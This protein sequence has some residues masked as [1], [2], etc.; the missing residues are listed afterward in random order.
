MTLD[1]AG[2][3]YFAGN[4]YDSNFPLT[5]G[6]LDTA[7]P[8]YP[9]LSLVVLKVDTTGK[10]VYST[11]IPT[12]APANPLNSQTNVLESTALAVD[13]NGQVTVAGTAGPGLPTTA[14]ALQPV[15]PNQT[16]GVAGFLLQLN[17]TA[18]ALNYATYL[19]G[20][21][22]AAGLAVAGD[23]S[24]YVA[25][26]TQELN[27][28]VSANAYDKALVQGPDCICGG[29]YILKLDSL[30]KTV[31]AATYLDGTSTAQNE[32]A[33]LLGI[34]LDSHSNVVVGGLTST[35]AF[36]LKNPFVSQSEISSSDVDLVVAELSS[37]LSALL[38]S[39][40]LNATTGFPYA[41]SLFTALA[42]DPT[43]H[44]ILAG[45]TYVNS[46][47]TTPGSFEPQ[48]PAQ[49]G[50]STTSHAFLASLNLAT[51]APSVCLNS[52]YVNFGLVP[53]QT[54]G[55]QS[56][57]LFNC[58]NAALHLTS[59][60]S[61]FSPVAAT[62]TCSDVAAGATCTIQLSFTPVNSA[63]ISGQMTLTDDAAIPTQIITFE[64]QGLAS[65]LV[66]NPTSINFGHLLVGTQGAAVPV[67]LANAGTGPLVI[68]AIST[69]GDFSIASNGCTAPVP[70]NQYCLISVVFTPTA[71]GARTGTVTIASND[72]VNPQ[73]SVRS[74]AWAM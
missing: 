26:F 28:P 31:I 2:N 47:P 9:N 59:Y 62:G 5:P 61:S 3:A 38:F 40:F 52:W 54:T 33:A 21:D 25:G 17:S 23:G 29:G 7:E 73:L 63:S 69:S 20:T 27:L 4:T 37:D 50:N 57:T 34:S 44:V 68:S 64:G 18:T 39:S 67:Y 60:L 49:P 24:L 1:S 70:S 8:A 72:P 66:P 51:P 43:D 16:S 55:S 32:G 53:M 10:L 14:G 12:N 46:F 48:L 22:S 65:Q 45:T 36:P 71:A 11:V 74:Q 56:L 58:G 35:T 30:A 13:S 15:F 19:P 42:L 41:G 6:S